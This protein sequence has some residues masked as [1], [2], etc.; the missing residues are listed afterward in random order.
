MNRFSFL[1]Y[2]VIIFSSLFVLTSCDKDFNEVGADIIGDS[3]FEFLSY[4]DATV[5]TYNQ[6]DPIVQTNNLPIN[7]LGVID[8]GVFGL[9]TSS[10]VTQVQLVNLNPEFP[11]TTIVDKVELA[12]PYYNTQ[13]T[14]D[15]TDKT[16]RLDSIYGTGK[17]NLQIFRTNK[18]LRNFNDVLLPQRYFSDEFSVFD[19]NISGTKLN[20]DPSVSENTEFKFS[21]LQQTEITLKTEDQSEIVTKVA[22]R[23]KLQLNKLFFQN[24]LID[25]KTNG[26]LTTNS[27]FQEYFRGLY[28]KVDAVSNEKGMALMNF[29][30]GKITVYYK[31]TTTGTRKTLVLNLIGNTVNLFQNSLASNTLP[32]NTIPVISTDILYLKGGAGFHS[33]LDLFG[34]ADATGVVPK[35]AIASIKNNNW[36]INEANLVF[37]I[38]ETRPTGE[39]PK[40][41]YIYDAKNKRPILDYVTDQSASTSKPKYS[42]VVHGGIYTEVKN[43]AGVSIAKKYKIRI[44]D[45]IKNIINRDST[46]VRLGVSVTEDISKIGNKYMKNTPDNAYFNSLPEASVINP[47]GTILYGSGASVEESKR[48]KLEIFYTKPN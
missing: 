37:T 25:A 24:L 38:N 42:K 8:N 34:T 18:F 4:N 15:G 27:L 35:E 41:I 21:P 20:D 7:Q 9:T 36:I 12:I 11:N 17:I 3:G 31:E 6:F 19:S 23:M 45:H 22:P 28:F 40:R 39:I 30:A 26:K 43:S 10:F 44:T 13:I 14:D 5:T 46:N 2:S 47:L 32:I 48:I 33:Y 1:K 16:Y 29:A